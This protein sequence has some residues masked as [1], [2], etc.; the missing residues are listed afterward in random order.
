MHGYTFAQ[1]V[2]YTHLI[3]EPIT[4]LIWLVI[5]DFATGITAAYRTATWDSKHGF[6]GMCKK[7]TMFLVIAFMFWLD[8][9][10][11]IHMLRGMA[12]S[13]F[14]IIEAM[15][16]LENIDRCGWGWV[17]PDFIRGKLVQI[18]EEKKI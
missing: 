9:A 1:A 6:R 5:V 8:V 15:S 7:A 3:D 14:A 18:R 16:I 12:I 11:Q 2:S 17:I 4:A 10:M 13:G